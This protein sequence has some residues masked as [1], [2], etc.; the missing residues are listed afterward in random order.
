MSAT[1][2]GL[3]AVALDVLV[4]RGDAGD[5]RVLEY[6]V[7]L[8]QNAVAVYER[9]A[10]AG[11]LRGP[12][13]QVARLFN[14]QSREQLEMLVKGLKDLGGTPPQPPARERIADLSELRD[15]DDALDFAHGLETG[16]VSG[17]RSAVRNL[18]KPELL[19]T[20]AEI[21]A[22]HGQRLVVLRQS[23]GRA[24]VPRAFDPPL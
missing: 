15:R 5:E 22:N 7:G 23:L 1:R 20:A 8:E 12:L 10:T 4:A 13:E 6:L 16:I 21:M 14:E 9:V 3:L 24:P 18:E 11:V 2:R 19:R 17:Y